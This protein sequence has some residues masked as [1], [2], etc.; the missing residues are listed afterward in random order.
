MSATCI[1]FA[2]PISFGFAHHIRWESPRQIQRD[3]QHSF[4][5][6]YV[7]NG[8]LTAKIYD[9]TFVAPAGSILI[10]FR[11]FPFEL[12]SN[13]QTQEYC[14]V[15]VFTDYTLSIMEDNEDFSP[16][17]SGLA[18]PVVTPP[19]SE[20][21]AIKKELFAIVSH[22]SIS[23]ENYA[24]S[25]AMALCGV[26]SKLD[27]LYREKLHKGKTAQSYWEYKIKRYVAEHI[28]E[29]ITLES[30]AVALGK[31]PNYLNGVFVKATGIGVHQYVN[32]EKM[33][34]VAML[35]EMRGFSFSQACEHAGI[36][37][38]SHGYRLF[39]KYLGVTPSAYIDSERVK[40]IDSNE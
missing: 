32:R 15:Q 18:L 5:I 6:V 24:F 16:D 17:F 34:L 4:V 21:E 26:L 30:L 10:L 2:S 38:I 7:K 37:D 20:T 29:K 40:A 8:E 22:L 3:L 35:M 31:T 39:K 28:S 25:S 23:R 27:M 19:G 33:Q 11:D 1:S 9:K 13:G 12:Y 36:T 14:S